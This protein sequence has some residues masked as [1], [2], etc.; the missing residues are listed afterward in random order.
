M[1]GKEKA[2]TQAKGQSVFWLHVPVA[3]VAPPLSRTRP[4]LARF[5]LQAP[6]VDLKSEAPGRVPVRPAVIMVGTLVVI[7]PHPTSIRPVSPY[8]LGWENQSGGG[9]ARREEEW[10]TCGFRVVIGGWGGN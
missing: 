5:W 8:T 2:G 10:A 9:G 4:V 1:Q 3:A 6:E 7:M